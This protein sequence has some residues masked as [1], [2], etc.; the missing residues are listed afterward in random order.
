MAYKITRDVPALKSEL[1]AVKT[2]KVVVV[3]LSDND[4]A[5]DL[6]RVMQALPRPFECEVHGRDVYVPH[7]KLYI[8]RKYL[9]GRLNP[10]M[11]RRYM[12]A[13]FY[14]YGADIYHR[15]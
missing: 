1:R 8:V 14:G 9:S 3:S 2:S 15:Q 6:R 10:E 7:H 12:P 4:A 11:Y 13:D 5:R